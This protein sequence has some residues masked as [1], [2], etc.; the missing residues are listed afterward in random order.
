M[1]GIKIINTQLTLQFNVCD[2]IK[3]IAI[4]KPKLKLCYDVAALAVSNLNLSPN[5]S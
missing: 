1:N 3:S 5:Y 4:A 2:C